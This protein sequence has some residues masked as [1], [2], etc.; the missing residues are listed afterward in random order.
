MT[1]SGPDQEP[2]GL[3]AGGVPGSRNTA[4]WAC[5]GPPPART[6]QRLRLV[7]TRIARAAPT[8]SVIEATSVP[9]RAAV[10]TDAAVVYYFAAEEIS[11]SVHE[12]EAATHRKPPARSDPPAHQPRAG[13]SGSPFAVV[14]V[15][16][17]TL[18]HR[19]RLGVLAALDQRIA[20][21]Y[22]IAGMSAA[23]T[24]DYIRHHCRIAGRDETLFSDDAIGL[25]RGR[26]TRTPARGERP[27]IARAYR[28]LRRRPRHRRRDRRGLNPTRI[29]P[30]TTAST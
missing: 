4:L 11:I 26:L 8:I 1:G 14:L 18:R 2:A 17:P 5:R 27:R 16:Q 7:V 30:T 19:L 29:N 10:D 6:A 12:P 13:L 24:A 28:R 15:G 3:A 25:I 21:R 9:D 22:T 23:D 20:V